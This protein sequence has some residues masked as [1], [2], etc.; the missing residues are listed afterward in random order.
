MMKISK[1][2]DQVDD[3]IVFL[4]M[5]FVFSIIAIISSGKTIGVI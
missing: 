3:D 1:I 5:F 2:L 4:M